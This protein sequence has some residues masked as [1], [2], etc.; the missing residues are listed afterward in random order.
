[1]N[2]VAGLVGLEGLLGDPCRE[3][4]AG[5]DE[6]EHADLGK[7]I[8]RSE[9]DCFADSGDGGIGKPAAFLGNDVLDGTCS[10][11]AAPACD[12]V[13]DRVLSEFLSQSRCVND[14]IEVV[15]GIREFEVRLCFHVRTFLRAREDLILA[16][17]KIWR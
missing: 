14:I 5:F 8:L 3:G 10:L 13:A 7:R 1:M 17:I 6:S 2:E 15:L 4:G 11:L 9:E 16:L 12:D